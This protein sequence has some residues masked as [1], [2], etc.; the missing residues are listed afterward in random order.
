MHANLYTTGRAQFISTHEQAMDWG[1]KLSK[2]G[3][4]IPAIESAHAFAVL[5]EMKFKKMIL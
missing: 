2:N 3:G 4:L 1:I 5:D